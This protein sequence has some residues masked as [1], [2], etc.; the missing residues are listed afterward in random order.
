MA[1]IHVRGTVKAKS[2]SHCVLKHN[3]DAHSGAKK[4]TLYAGSQST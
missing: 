2:I 3:F 4:P 1:K